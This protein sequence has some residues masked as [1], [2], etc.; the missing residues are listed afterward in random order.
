MPTV[1]LLHVSD[2]HQRG[3]R[4]A[5]DR[6]KRRRVLGDA[7]VRN[8]EDLARTGPIDLLCFTG[9]LADWGLP[10]EYAG[11]TS[12]FDQL[13]TYT[14][15]PHERLVLVPGNHDIQRRTKPRAWKKVRECAAHNQ[16]GVATWLAGQGTPFGAKD[17]WREAVLER[18]RAFWDYLHTSLG[19]SHL[20][21]RSSRHGRLGYHHQFSLDGRPFP[22]H[23]VGLD[24]AW[25]CGDDADAGKILLTEEQVGCHVHDSAGQ[26]LAGLRIALVHHP[27]TELADGPACRR[28]L[29]DRVDLLLCGHVHETEVC[30]MVEPGRE[31]RQLAAGCLYE[32]AHGHRW[33][34]SCQL[35]EIETTDEGRPLRYT[36]RFRS[37]SSRGFWHD[38]PSLYSGAPSG[39]LQWSVEGAQAVSPTVPGPDS[40]ATV[41]GSTW[42]KELTN[43]LMD[44]FDAKFL[45]I[46]VELNFPIEVARELPGEIASLSELAFAVVHLGFK[47]GVLNHGFFD[48]LQ[49]ARK[50][51]TEEISELR[52]KWLHAQQKRPLQVSVTTPVDGGDTRQSARVEASE[53]QTRQAGNHSAPTSTA[54]ELDRLAAWGTILEACRDDRRHLAFLVHGTHGQ[55]LRAFIQRITGYL[56]HHAPHHVRQVPRFDDR[57]QAQTAAQWARQFVAATRPGTRRLKLE[58]LLVKESRG[59]PPLWIFTEHG[60][61]LKLDDD[62]SVEGLGE[63]LYSKLSG[64]LGTVEG[65]LKHPIR[66]VLPVSHRD[67]GRPPEVARL[68]EYLGAAKNLVFA[69]PLEVT[70]PPLKEVREFLEDNYPTLAEKIWPECEAL[71]KRVTSNPD[72]ALRDLTNPLHELIDRHLDREIV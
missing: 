33:P 2:L 27:L 62:A 44:H 16:A 8:L 53:P 50:Q 32:G 21:P 11:A 46:W 59:L 13:C 24:S 28:L 63:F 23:V 34:N 14:N 31:L 35:I 38:D 9:D 4:E 40:V 64:A 3:E 26:A 69:E 39:I 66:V 30:A 61:P 67:K 36:V 42:Q 52:Q 71:Y 49:L 48:E 12:F 7:W 22:V 18:S 15:V 45:R 72:P 58:T 17:V 54:V 68:S 19:L 60:G 47:H 41:G 51:C 65:K 57:L 43:F 20:D 6:W 1:R 10:E 29:A 55:D 56:H 37:W 5:R 70:F 25:L